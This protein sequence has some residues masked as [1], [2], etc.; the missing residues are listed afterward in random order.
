MRQQI[1]ELVI[2]ASRLARVLLAEAVHAALHGAQIREDQLGV[3]VPQLARGL[4]RRPVGETAHDEAERI[5]VGKRPQRL[6]VHRL[7]A[8][9]GQIDEAHL[10]VGHFARFID[11]GELIDATVGY[12]DRA[13]VDVRVARLVQRRDGVEQRRLAGERKPD[14]SSL[15]RGA[16]LALTASPLV[17]SGDEPAVGDI[18]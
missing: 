6:G 5:H 17:G 7:A 14:E 9:A 12:L 16:K 11:G 4:R 3:E 13:Q 2:F 1:G 15:R 8:R 18:E 10:R